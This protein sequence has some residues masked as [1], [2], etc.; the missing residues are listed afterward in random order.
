MPFISAGA[1]ECRDLWPQ[2][3]GA[4]FIVREC[5]EERSPDVSFFT[6]HSFWSD[7]LGV[8]GFPFTRQPDTMRRRN[9]DPFSIS[10]KSAHICAT[11]NVQLCYQDT[12]EIDVRNRR[13]M[14]H[15]GKSSRHANHERDDIVDPTTRAIHGLSLLL[16]SCI[17]VVRN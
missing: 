6:Q 12:W 9:I 3:D 15:I 8:P 5:S 14:W 17:E 10:S 11:A 2:F 7:W 4:Q 13:Q 16:H 1:F